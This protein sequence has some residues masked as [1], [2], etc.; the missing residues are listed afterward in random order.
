MEYMSKEEVLRKIRTERKH[1][2]IKK[3]TVKVSGKHNKERELR[4]CNTHRM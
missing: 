1:V 3:E 4:E 2:Y